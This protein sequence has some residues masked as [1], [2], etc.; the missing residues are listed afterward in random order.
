QSDYFAH[1]VAD[2]SVAKGAR[3]LSCSGQGISASW[4]D[5]KQTAFGGRTRSEPAHILAGFGPTTARSVVA[6]YAR[7]PDVHDHRAGRCDAQRTSRYRAGWCVWLFRRLDRSVHPTS[8]RIATIGSDY[9]DLAGTLRRVAARLDTAAGVFCD[10]GD[11]VVDR[12]DHL[13][14]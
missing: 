7:H 9:S 6:Y 1:G 14:A 13:G 5:S 2:R 3:W 10:Y 12:L 8:D 4:G 11:P